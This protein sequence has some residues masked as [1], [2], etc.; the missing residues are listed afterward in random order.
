M[1]T[2][3][4]FWSHFLREHFNRR[5]YEEFKDL[6]AADAAAGYRYGTH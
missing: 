1:N 5:L 4:R 2:L 6:A 3:Y